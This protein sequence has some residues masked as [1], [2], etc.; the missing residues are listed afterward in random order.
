MQSSQL[1]VNERHLES[2][3]NLILVERLI[4]FNS[5]KRQDLELM[6][7]LINFIKKENEIDLEIYKQKFEKIILII[8]TYNI[9]Y[10]Y[11]DTNIEETI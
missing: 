7:Q 6:E 5:V 8:Q 11:F 2:L 9:F 4:I 1:E 10:S 3:D